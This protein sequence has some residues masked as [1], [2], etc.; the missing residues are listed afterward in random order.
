MVTLL[1]TMFSIGVG[2][3]SML[4]AKLLKGEVSPRHVPFA[5]LGISIFCWDFSAAAAAADGLSDVH[6]ILSS[7]Q[8]WRMLIDLTLLSACG[9][10]F[11]VPLYALVQHNSPDDAR[12]R[13]I[14]ANNVVNA[15]FMVIGA[16]AAFAFDAYGVSSTTALAIL[17]AANLLVAIWIVRLLP[18]HVLRALFPFLFQYVPRRQRHRSG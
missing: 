2:A 11:S 14:A 12:A 5:A 10:A 4:C 15:I 1:L 9:G 8:G 16:A 17:A 7:F 18:Q 3:G 6:A 13:I